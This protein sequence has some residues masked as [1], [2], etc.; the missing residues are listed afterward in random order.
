ML[1]DLSINNAPNTVKLNSNNTEQKVT[2]DI[3]SYLEQEKSSVNQ[4]SLSKDIK[5]LLLKQLTVKEFV[6]NTMNSNSNKDI[7]E[8]LTILKNNN[9][10]AEKEP[11]KELPKQMDKLLNQT[12]QQ[13]KQENVA[14]M[15]N[16]PNVQMTSPESQIIASNLLALIK[17]GKL[18]EAYQNFNNK[19]DVLEKMLDSYL[20][21]SSQSVKESANLLNFIQNIIAQGLTLSPDLQ[22]LIQEKYKK[23]EKYLSF[24]EELKVKNEEELDTLSEKAQE[25]V[26]N[27]MD[28]RQQL[29][30]LD[31]DSVAEALKEYEG[32]LKMIGVNS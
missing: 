15:D 8:I 3:Q 20:S 32:L 27:V 23:L 17:E 21:Q 6:K 24:S 16:K 7:E 19:G 1:N 5:G 26:K 29:E 13:V 31:S 25:F 30:F 11:I 18:K 14:V 4:E 2:K 22:K 9:I 28:L 12:Q 10:E